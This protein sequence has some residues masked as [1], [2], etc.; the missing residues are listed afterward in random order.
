MDILGRIALSA[1]WKIVTILEPV[2]KAR[3][4]FFRWKATTGIESG[5]TGNVLLAPDVVQ[6]ETGKI[7]E[8]ILSDKRVTF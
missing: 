6:Q 2:I 5:C 4:P 8:L 7:S 1:A 3:A